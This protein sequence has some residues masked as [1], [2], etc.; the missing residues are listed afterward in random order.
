VAEPA[1]GY[2]WDLAERAGITFRNFGEF[3]NEEG[4]AGDRRYIGT[5]RFLAAHTDSLYPWF[6][7]GIPD[8]RRVDVWLAQFR[9]WEAAGEMPALQT[10]HLPRD[11]TQG[12]AERYNTP[13]AMV[14]DND[15]ALG[16]IVEAV[17]RSRFWAS[18]AIVVLEDDAQDGPDHVDSHRSPLLIVSPWT[19]PGVY[20][21][22]ANTTDVLRTIEELLGLGQLSQFDRWGRPLREIWAERPDSAPYAAITPVQPLDAMN[23]P[24]TRAARETRHLDLSRVDAADMDRFNRVLWM[25]VKGEDAPYPGVHRMAA[26]EAWRSR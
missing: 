25:A 5:K 20:H 9:Q 4:E 2:L 15:L 8:Q 18:T 12:A 24:R 22:F 26:L 23:P 1:Q 7:M 14:A 11:H 16:R 3:V 6:D 17:S 19:R 13:S 21:R 10:M